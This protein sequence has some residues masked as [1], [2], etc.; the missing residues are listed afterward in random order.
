MSKILAVEFY[1]QSIKFMEGSR[2][3]NTLSITKEGEIDLPVGTIS[4]GVVKDIEFVTDVLRKLPGN[5]VKHKKSIFLINSN[6][7]FIR[8]I[9]LP[10]VKSYKETRAMINFKLQEML[11]SYFYQY[12]IMYKTSEIFMDEG[13]KKA[14][15]IVYGMPLKLYEGYLNISEKLQLNLKSIDISSN[16]INC[17]LDKNTV[18]G[19]S[20]KN[21]IIAAINAGKSS[22]N[23]SIINKGIT[24]LF[25]IAQYDNEGTSLI[26]QNSNGTILKCI[27]EIRKYVKY[28]AS[29]EKD[30][31]IEKIYLFGESVIDEVKEN[32][33][34]FGA[35]VETITEIPGIHID[36]PEVKDEFFNYFNLSASFYACKNHID[37]LTEKKIRQ[38][39]RLS[40]GIAVMSVIIIISSVLSY[41]VL[42]F[43]FKTNML[44][45]EASSKKIFLSN[46]DNILLNNEIENIKKKTVFF[47]NYIIMAD[48]IKERVKEDNLIS[49]ELFV[50]IKSCAPD[51]TIINSFFT[52]VNNVEINCESSSLNSVALFVENLRNIEFV[53]NVNMTNVTVKKDD[54]VSKYTYAVTC[55]LKG[56]DY[57]EQ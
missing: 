52:D 19:K 17:I 32:L 30:N 8:K 7:V 24:E 53:D 11:P 40:V 15:Y 13:V 22:M 29:S 37:F 35:E 9:E 6:S 31:K 36:G 26:E 41:N 4:D 45:N 23:L 43:Y 55:Y 33:S 49:S 44:E 57:E 27:E 16:F 34:D 54:G 46:E 2:K 38:K 5:S 25:R 56:V 3:R 14:R 51:D 20:I 39:Y 10:Y 28:Y 18:N 48:E 42:R 50:K 21:D 47:E 12:K 1:D